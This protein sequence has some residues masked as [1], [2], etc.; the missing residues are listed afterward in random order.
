MSG[1]PILDLVAGIIFIFFLLSVISSSVVEVIMTLSRARS[2]VLE[3]W[4][5]SIFDQK[6][7]GS[8]ISL[9]QSIMDHCSITASSAKG[10]SNSYIDA[11]NFVSAF[12]EKIT[13]NPDDPESVATDFKT[14]M[15]QIKATP[16]L[17]DELKRVL[18][19]YAVE[20]NDTY[21][22][23][24]EK[25]TGKFEMFRAKVETWF[26]SSMDRITG[27]L[28]KKYMQPITFCV[29]IFIT[30]LMNADTIAISRYLYSNKDAQ[31]KFANLAFAASSNEGYQHTVAKID[32]MKK[33]N[34]KDSATLSDI[35]SE[36][37]NDV[38]TINSAKA[39]L[40][41]G[42]PLGWKNDHFGTDNALNKIAGWLITIFAIFMG[43][44][45][46]FDMLNKI[47]NLRGS[48]PKPKSS[49]DKK[50]KK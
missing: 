22:S 47:A 26:D 8:N 17:N 5:T 21:E 46:W 36:I 37:N 15:E 20:V 31:A 50:S 44:P 39:Q 45:F 19:G 33:G 23:V 48:G 43:A 11:K 40:A 30:L 42:L 34:P 49:T 25:T 12:L 41:D 14:L 6:L 27:A 24:S 9:G 38:A 16:L 3:E 35:K 29:G 13:Y 10:Q 1:F 32:S 7:P 18:L 28:K 4:L 2:K